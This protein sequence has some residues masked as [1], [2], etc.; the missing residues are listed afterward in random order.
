M[1]KLSIILVAVVALCALVAVEAQDMSQVSL[2]ATN[3][4]LGVYTNTTRTI[5]PRTGGSKSYEIVLQNTG[6]YDVYY[7]VDA[8]TPSSTKGIVL[9]GTYSATNLNAR[10]EAVIPW[11]NGTVTLAVSTAATTTTNTIQVSERWISRYP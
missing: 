11:N 1:K 7:T 5:G 10:S 4:S 6:A 2:S 9:A 8:S 3:Y